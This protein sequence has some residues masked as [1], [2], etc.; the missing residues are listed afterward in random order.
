MM[1][2]SFWHDRWQ[3]NRIAF[4]LDEANPLLVHYFRQLKQTPGSRVFVPLCGKTR[5]IGWLLTQG[6][7]VVGAELVESAIVQLFADLGVEPDIIEHGPLKHFHAPDIDI[8]VGDV[9][10]LTPALV[11]DIDAVYDRAA[12]VALPE[13]MRTA[14]AH[15][16]QQLAAD[17]AQLLISYQ[18]DQNA[19][20]GPPFSVSDHEVHRLYGD[21]YQ[22]SVLARIDVPG[23]MKGQTPAEELLWLLVPH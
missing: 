17:A 20:A 6:Y 3:N 7:R 21:A 15:Q 1:E 22:L 16:M 10:E 12:L 14:Y 18:Y 19:I 23:G 13:H 4:H 8:W 2:A 5:D 11:G 9:L